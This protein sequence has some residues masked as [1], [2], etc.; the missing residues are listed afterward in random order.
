MINN[1]KKKH[2]NYPKKTERNGV[3]EDDFLIKKSFIQTKF[4]NE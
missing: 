3:Q 4:Q 2:K 1:N